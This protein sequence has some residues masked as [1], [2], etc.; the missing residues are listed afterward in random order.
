MLALRW[1][2]VKK[3]TDCSAA[4]YEN[5]HSRGFYLFLLPS[6]LT[7]R[8]PLSVAARCW[9]PLRG[10]SIPARNPGLG[11]T[12]GGKPG[13]T[14]G[15]SSEGLARQDIRLRPQ[16]A[17]PERHQAPA[18]R[19]QR[20]WGQPN[21]ASVA[22]NW[23]QLKGRGQPEPKPS[24]TMTRT[25]D[26]PVIRREAGAGSIGYWATSACDHLTTDGG[27]RCTQGNSP[28]YPGQGAGSFLPLSSPPPSPRM[29]EAG[30]AFPSTAA[31]ESRTAFLSTLFTSRI[32][33]ACGLGG[34]RNRFHSVCITTACSTLSNNH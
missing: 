32:I 10:T 17:S 34:Q 26:L 6:F 15:S 9:Q 27:R 4:G 8:R 7:S 21:S 12:P 23:P 31:W 24:L 30:R 33:T 2:K 29:P 20:G 16:G 22:G 18:P 1:E 3:L 28:K 11:D 13:N 19:P 25:C 5:P 14:P